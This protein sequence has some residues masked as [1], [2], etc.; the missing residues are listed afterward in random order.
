MK[1]DFYRLG[2]IGIPKNGNKMVI[3]LSPGLMKT[4]LPSYMYKNLLPKNL[5]QILKNMAIGFYLAPCQLNKDHGLKNWNKVIVRDFKILPQKLVKTGLLVP[6][7]AKATI[8]YFNN[9]NGETHTEISD[10]QILHHTHQVKIF[11]SS[12]WV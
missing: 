3:I 9:S 11:S 10:S 8:N 1:R 5:L 6:H 12:T 2:I 4:I 7:G